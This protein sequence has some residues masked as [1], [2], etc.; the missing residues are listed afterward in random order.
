MREIKYTNVVAEFFGKLKAL[1]V[2]VVFSRS[3]SLS[4]AR[5]DACGF[6]AS[7]KNFHSWLRLALALALFRVRVCACGCG[8]TYLLSSI[9]ALRA[10]RVCVRFLSLS[11]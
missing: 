8:Q 11:L 10:A 5:F 2:V 7:D 9:R 3:F 1:P 6:V 4:R